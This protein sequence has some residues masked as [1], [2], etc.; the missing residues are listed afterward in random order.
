MAHDAYVDFAGHFIFGK[1]RRR[2]EHKQ[3]GKK[4]GKNGGINGREVEINEKLRD[5][6]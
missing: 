3:A 1:C 2:G 6:K 5:D 4:H